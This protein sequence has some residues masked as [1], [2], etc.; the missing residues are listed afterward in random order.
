MQK[1]HLKPKRK[2]QKTKR[3]NLSNNTKTRRI[4]LDVP[5]IHNSKPKRIVLKK[6]E[7]NEEE[8]DVIEIIKSCKYYHS[9]YVP[10]SKLS[11]DDF[12][13]RLTESQKNAWISYIESF[14]SRILKIERKGIQAILTLKSSK[15]V[16]EAKRCIIFLE[17]RIK[18]EIEPES[19]RKVEIQET[20][21]SKEINKRKTINVKRKTGTEKERKEKRGRN[22]GK[23]N[24]NINKHTSKSKRKA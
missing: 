11:S 8:L 4:S 9:S 20:D 6:R 23:E 17:E 14:D 3:I 18:D 21:R 24:R 10:V 19:K 22:K 2:K 13:Y 7:L 12:N 16:K 15:S 5:N 1:I